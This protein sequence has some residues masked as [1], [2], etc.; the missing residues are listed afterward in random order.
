MRRNA[1]GKV[2]FDVLDD[3]ERP[4]GEILAVNSVTAQ[5]INRRQQKLK[6]DGKK[7]IYRLRDLEVTD[8]TRQFI[9]DEISRQL[10]T[11]GFAT[12]PANGI[13]DSAKVETAAAMTA[14]A[15]QGS[16]KTEPEYTV[17]DVIDAI[18]SIHDDENVDPKDPRFTEKG[19]PSK[20]WVEERIGFEV[21]KA[22]YL[23]AIRKSK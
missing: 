3:E 18:M 4:T 21:N 8:K 20:A 14:K 12:R 6:A 19:N 23:E 15:T 11:H 2:E 13:G 5:D 1:N 10:K 17:D 22:I 7:A 9:R 16:E